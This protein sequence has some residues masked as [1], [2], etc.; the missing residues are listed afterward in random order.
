MWRIKG[1][2]KSAWKK[3]KSVGKK[4][5]TEVKNKPST[6]TPS[7]VDPATQTVGKWTHDRIIEA[8][9]FALRITGVYEGKGYGQIS[10][11]FDGQGASAGVFQWCFGQGSLQ[12]EIINPLVERLGKKWVDDF[13]PIPI[14]DATK[15]RSCTDWVE[16]VMQYKKGGKLRYKNIWY[17]AWTTFLTHPEVVKQQVSASEDRANVAVKYLNEAGLYDLKSFCFMLDIVVQNGSPK[18]IKKPVYNR[19]TRAE[20]RK[21][22]NEVGGTNKSIWNSKPEDQITTIL[23]VWA[24]RRALRNRWR[25]DVL[26][27]KITIAHGEGIVHSKRFKIDY[28]NKIVGIG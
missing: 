27:R 9:N 11:N 23:T 7:T 1:F 12:R 13:F 15:S 20:Y 3:I 14:V 2:F 10:T 17:T 22:V 19:Q 5:N 4:K 6:H 24:G 28:E 21:Y 25:D 16:D 18:G 26:R 8:L